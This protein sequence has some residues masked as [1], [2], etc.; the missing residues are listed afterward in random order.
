MRTVY[1]RV[2][3]ATVLG[4]VLGLA[5]GC[6]SPKF[7]P[8][9]TYRIAGVRV[10]GKLLNDGW[11]AYTMY[12][13]ACHGEH[14]DGNGVAAAGYHPP[15]RN[16]TKGIFKFAG[17]NGAGKLPSD[18]DL[19]RII[20]YG[21]NGTPMLAWD[22]PEYERRAI[23]Q[24][25]KTMAPLPDP[26]K[27]HDK[28]YKVPISPWYA[29]NKKQEPLFVP[30][31]KDPYE[32]GGEAKA[33]E[34]GKLVY[35]TKAQC[36]GCHPSYLT[37][38]EYTSFLKKGLEIG[39]MTPGSTLSP[40]EDAYNPQGKD[41]VDYKSRLLPPDFLRH[42]VRSV[43]VT[44]PSAARGI[45]PDSQR[46]EDFYRIIANGIPGTA[47]PSWQKQLKPDEL[48][49]L[50]HYVKWL[51][52]KQLPGGDAR[53]FRDNLLAQPPYVAPEP[54]PAPVPVPSVPSVGD[55]A[56]PAGATEPEASPAP[57]VSPATPSQP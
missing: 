1:T 23:I 55:V 25:I 20:R 42:P 16:F 4:A 40:R 43:R 33:L 12:C 32:V 47:M 36:L 49:A 57:A 10:T 51:H 24:Y 41:S 31:S 56:P 13:A 26:K 21:L 29:K 11:E 18:A 30:A 7:K 17:V 9:G 22:I 3:I 53:A 8:N 39:F 50:T 37:T 14:G 28:G 54:A 34:I 46:L 44:C 38:E 6:E 35:H 27:M 19:D 48:W 15:P 2:A 5:A 52:D 45:C